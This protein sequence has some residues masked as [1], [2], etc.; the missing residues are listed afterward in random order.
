MNPFEGVR[1][2]L[3]NLRSHKLRTF[4]TLL[5]NIVGTM[6]VIAVWSL[7]HG[8][9]R[10]TREVVLDEGTGVFSITRTGGIGQVLSD[11][12]AYLESLNNPALTLAD[13]AY[14]QEKLE[15]AEHV[16]AARSASGSL[17]AAG[18]TYQGVGIR[19]RT[20]EYPDL[21]DLPLRLGRH[22]N[23]SDVV[24]SRLVAVLGSDVAESLFPRRSDPTGREF[25]LGDRHFT[26]VGVAEPRSSGGGG[27]DRDRFAVIPLTAFQKVYGAGGSVTLRVAVADLTRMEEAQ[28]EAVFY[29]RQRHRLRPLEGDDFALQ[30]S[31]QLLSL[32]S[33]ISRYIGTTLLFL[34]GI[35]LVV[36]GIVL[37][38]V[39]LV[40]VTQRTREVGVRKAIGA[41]RN[42]VL[43]QFLV[44][45]VTLAVTG[46]LIGIA[47]GVLLAF[48]V[49]LVSPLP[50]AL[51]QAAMIIGLV[52]NFLIG[53]VFGTYPA[54][55]AAG[56]DPVEAL[57][58][59]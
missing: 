31:E 14:L 27:N 12:D 1:I 56:L 47:I 37:M 46:G 11:Y 29:L 3:E 34:V 8:V 41:S 35:S 32:W 18:E 58:Y 21:E 53:V 42:A 52:V 54:W 48:I 49:T 2:A 9:D 38:N 30:D 4:L 44:E 7:M 17:R 6:A 20:E 40:S 50:F 5:G 59:E 28:A 51:A 10:Y 22:L 33:S 39:M 15:L 36:G 19:G 13:R 24:A 55:K 23:R 45:S 26:V 16:G 25:R 57:R 43:W